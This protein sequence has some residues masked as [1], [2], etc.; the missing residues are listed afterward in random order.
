MNKQKYT[1]FGID[2][3]PIV[4]HF[5]N[6]EIRVQ[7]T[8]YLTSVLFVNISNFEHIVLGQRGFFDHFDVKFSYNRQQIE[9]TPLK[10]AKRHN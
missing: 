6:I 1:I 3:N 7:N 5:A 4:G 10:S 9:I 2:E 8:S